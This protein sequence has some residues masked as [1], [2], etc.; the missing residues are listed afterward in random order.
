MIITILYPY[1]THLKYATTVSGAEHSGDEF[2]VTE[3]SFPWKIV[4]FSSKVA[5][6]IQSLLVR[7]FAGP[8]EVQEVVQNLNT[9]NNRDLSVVFA[10][11][12]IN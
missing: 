9:V 1:V 11:K 4:F 6:S 8:G 10:E 7:D 12:L 2:K 5:G 3:H